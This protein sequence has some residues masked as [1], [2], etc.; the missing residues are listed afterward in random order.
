[1]EGDY[2]CFCTPILLQSWNQCL[3]YRKQRAVTVFRY[4]ENRAEFT[5]KQG[6]KLREHERESGE[7][8]IR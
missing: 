8:R 6:K 1:M 3:G 7:R 2:K 4:P 5:R